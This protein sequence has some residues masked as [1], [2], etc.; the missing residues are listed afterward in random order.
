MATQGNYLYQKS[1]TAYTS[2]STTTIFNGISASFTAKSTGRVLVHMV[3]NSKNDTT[4]KGAILTLKYGTGAAPTANSSTSGVGTQ[5]GGLAENSTG[6]G[7]NT[8]YYFQ[9]SDYIQLISGTTYWFD[10]GLATTSAGSTATMSGYSLCIVEFSNDIGL[11]SQ[12]TIPSPP[13]GTNN[14]FP[15][16]MMGLG[17]TMFI[18]PNKTGR[19]LFLFNGQYSNGTNGKGG[20]T[21]CYHGTGTAPAN[22]A[23]LTGTQFNQQLVFDAVQGASS[24]YPFMQNGIVIGLSIGTSHWFDTGMNATGAN[25]NLADLYCQ[26]IEF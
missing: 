11:A 19:V 7:A 6:N 8:N 17:S 23:A 25:S 3:G 10:T 16:V 20:S 13:G 24:G 22:G 18:T 21:Y 15:G 5:I 12:F 9:I 26:L 1:S 14:I 4:L 2:T